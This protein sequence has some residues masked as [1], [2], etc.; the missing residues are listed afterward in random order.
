MAISHFFARVRKLIPKSLADDDFPESRKWLETLGISVL[1]LGSA[2]LASPADPAL[3]KASFPWLWFAPMLISLLYGVVPGLM[4]SLLIIANWSLANSL[5]LSSTE[6]PRD[7]FVGGGLL[8]LICGEFSEVWR[9][10]NMRMDET[11]LY[12]S[13]RLA[14]LTKRHFLLNL[15]HDRLEQEMLA[16]PGSL[17][18]ALVQ[19]RRFIIQHADTNTPLPGVDELLQLLA[20]YC[21]IEAASAYLIDDQRMNL[22]LGPQQATIGE[23]TA[24]HQYDALLALVQE[25]RTL[26]HI[27]SDEVSLKR[28]SEQLIVAPIITSDNLVLGV[29]AINRIPFFSLN[30]E[31]LQMIGVILAYYADN[32]RVSSE[33]RRIQQCVP[34]IPETFAEETARMMRLKRISRIT[35][36]IA[37]LRFNGSKRD[38][39]PAQLLRI[40]R[41]LDVFWQTNLGDTPVIAILMPFGSSAA[42]DGF[43]FRIDSWLKTT[44]GGGLDAQ[45]VSIQA[46]D[47]ALEDPVESL[48]KIFKP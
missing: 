20:Q 12:I 39:I 11:N 24:L 48:R 25:K 32:L 4:S 33:V 6:F 42:M 21:N 16:R 9:D 40:K 35:S 43:T 14:R 3:V 47:F 30:A 18:D 46:I 41:G 26:A 36:H 13:E 29:L 2:W 7:T 45:Q 8:V 31:N 19:M 15:S 22:R 38:E 17:R 10:R 23:A 27:A 44:F 5:G 1:I 28:N 34:G 37:L